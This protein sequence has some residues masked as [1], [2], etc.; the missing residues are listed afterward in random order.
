MLQV[1]NMNYNASASS[2][3]ANN[4]VLA[5]FNFNADNY[6]NY[7]FNVNFNSIAAITN[8]DVEA[9]FVSFKTQVIDIIEDNF[10][11]VAQSNTE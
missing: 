10:P 5:T 9:D 3:G 7:N 8:A 4:E 2:V 1:N 6:G 11:A